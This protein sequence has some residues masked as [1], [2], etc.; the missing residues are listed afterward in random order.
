MILP[1]LF[2][3]SKI[4]M[5]HLTL[6]GSLFQFSTALCRDADCFSHEHFCEKGDS[7]LLME[8]NFIY[9]SRP[10]EIDLSPCSSDRRTTNSGQKRMDQTGFIFFL[11]PLVL[12]LLDGTGDYI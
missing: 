5:S 11:T 8:M 4:N 3:E 9:L 7:L 1:K 6:G 12:M 10:P 2:L